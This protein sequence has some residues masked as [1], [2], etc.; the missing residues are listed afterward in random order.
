ML[1]R[2]QDGPFTLVV[3]IGF[4]LLL[5]IKRWPQR[6]RRTRS[7]DWPTVTG[8]V[9]NGEVSTGRGKG[10]YGDQMIERASATLAYS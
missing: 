3:L 4:A 2:L 7:A 9:E 5:A 6:L 1:S 10:R 8:T